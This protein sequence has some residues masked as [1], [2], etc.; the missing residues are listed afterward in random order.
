M[1]GWGSVFSAGFGSEVEGRMRF[2]KLRVAWSVTWGILAVLV[3]VLWVRSYRIDDTLY[4]PF[5][6]F[7]RPHSFLVESRD[8]RTTLCA[9]PCGIQHGESWP[10]GLNS[11]WGFL[12][13]SVMDDFLNQ[14]GLWSLDDIQDF[15]IVN[16]S[17]GELVINIPHWFPAMLFATLSA[18][19]WIRWRFTL[20][21]LLIAITAVAVVLGLI[22]WLSR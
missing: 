1:L 10:W 9:G 2:R 7:G 19:P 20:R 21:T 18:A 14:I 16:S 11:Q 8:G 5:H 12:H 3:C 15:Q 4:G 17:R 13:E 22:V 6:C